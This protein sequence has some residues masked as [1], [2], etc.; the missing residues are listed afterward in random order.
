MRYIYSILSLLVLLTLSSNIWGQN[1]ITYTPV[2]NANGVDTNQDLI[3]TFDATISFNAGP[4]IPTTKNIYLYNTDSGLIVDTWTFALGLALSGDATGNGTNVLT[5]N[6]SIVLEPGTN[7]HVIIEDGA[8]Q[9]F[10]GIDDSEANNWRFTTTSPLLYN[11]VQDAV[12]V[13]LDQDLTLTFPGSIT[14][15]SSGV[16][17]YIQLYSDTEVVESWWIVAGYVAPGISIEGNLLTINPSANLQEGIDYYITID[18]GAL[19]GFVGIDNS[20]DNNWRFTSISYPPVPQVYLPVQNAVGVGINQNPVITFDRDI[21]FKTLTVGEFYIRISDQISGLPVQSFIVESGNQD[22]LLVINNNQLTINLRADLLINTQYYITIPTGI[23]ESTTGAVFDG[24]NNGP[25][26]NWR[27]TTVGEPI[28]ALNYPFTENIT[29]N[30][31]DIVGQTDKSGTYY[32]VVTSNPTAP[33]STQIKA[34]QDETGSATSF[35]SGSGAMTGSVDF[36]ETL[37]ISNHTLYL[38]ETNYYVHFIT[39]EN[40]NTLDSEIRSTSFTT[41]ERT[42]PVASFIPIDGTNGVSILTNVVI[43]FDEP[44]RMANGTIIDDTNVASLITFEQNPAIQVAFT[45]TIDPTKQIITIVPNAPL[46]DDTN[47]TVIISAVEDYLGNEQAGSSQTSFTTAKVVTWVGG[48]VGSETNWETNENWSSNLSNSS[49]VHIPAGVTFMPVINTDAI[50]GSIN[51]EAGASLEIN[52]TGSLVINETLTMR[53]STSGLGNA[54]LIDNGYN[55]ISV[56]PNKVAIH[57]EIAASDRSYHVSSPVSNATKTN[58]GVDNAIYQFDNTTDSWSLLGD[59]Q[60]LSSGTG[61]VLRSGSNVTFTGNLN[62]NSVYALDLTRTDGAGYGWNLVG[63]PYTAALNWDNANILK[64]NIND[65]YWI[66]LNDASNYGIYGTYSSIGGGTHGLDNLIP[67]HQGYFVK[68][69]IGSPTGTIT[70]GK[71]A[72]AANNKSIL[73]SSKSI[74]YPKIKLAGVNGEFIDETIIAFADIADDNRGHYD[75]SK[76]FGTNNNYLQ[77]FSFEETES[78]AINCKQEIKDGLVI[79]IGFK[80]A[81]EGTYKIKNVSSEG[82][83]EQYDVF[84]E[85]RYENGLLTNLNEQNEY[86]FTT[87]KKGNVVDRFAIHFSLKTVTEVITNKPDNILIYSDN[88]TIFINGKNTLGKTY[89]IHSLNGTVIENGILQK[90][91]L[92][93]ININ[94]SGLYIVRIYDSIKPISKKILLK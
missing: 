56:D 63:N 81:N 52:N 34:G 89:E 16:T 59:N 83:L 54:S 17:K 1:I 12:D 8:L 41:L 27:F 30:S 35:T 23:I 39:N 53:S 20:N 62:Q 90:N 2:Q 14:F 64:T 13:P 7:Y 44:V 71:S 87:T 3:L 77:I 33:T 65:A 19:N 22:A 61:Y 9:G 70:M 46:T 68:V 38:A 69:E 85:D 72:L 28:W 55:P 88:K 49:I 25:D 67:S 66:F 42:P 80:A 82:I 75:A 37:D 84:L 36:R 92:N 32:Y 21:R 73:K 5:L 43:S 50:V 93:S 40:V 79:P 26:N 18:D 47:H 29:P 10:P 48:T 91:G 74:S 94:H 6:P 15:N 60:T 4:P 11:P 51:I 45:A 57:Q 24:I 78:Y 86:E 31:V 58:M 76:K